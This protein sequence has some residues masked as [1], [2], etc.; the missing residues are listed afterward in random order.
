MEPLNVISIDRPDQPNPWPRILRLITLL[1]LLFAGS[2][3][4]LD[5]RDAFA[6]FE[7]RAT[8]SQTP[9]RWRVIITFQTALA[10]IDAVVCAAMLL[11]AILL[12]KRVASTFLITIATRMWFFLWFLGIIVW[13]ISWSFRRLEYLANNALC[14]AFP[15]LILWLLR[16]YENTSP[17]FA[18]ASLDMPNNAQASPTFDR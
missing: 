14:V 17:A 2:Q 3:L 6:A 12:I 15:V 4:L 5:V 8:V 1:T 18:S 9:F 7:S 11:G 10:V 13:L 16:E